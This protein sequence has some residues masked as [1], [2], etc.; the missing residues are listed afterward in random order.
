MFVLV[1]NSKYNNLKCKKYQH[2]FLK[3]NSKSILR[4]SQYLKY[5]VTEMIKKLS[6]L[7][8]FRFKSKNIIHTVLVFL[9]IF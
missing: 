7:M 3:K 5:R 4:N 1:Q 2:S 8:V 9:N 6:I